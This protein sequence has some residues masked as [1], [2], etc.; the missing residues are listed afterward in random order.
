M[1]ILATADTPSFPFLW[2]TNLRGQFAIAF[3]DCTTYAPDTA[4]L[5][6]VDDVHELLGKMGCRIGGGEG[7]GFVLRSLTENSQIVRLAA[8]RGSV[9]HG[10]GCRKVRTEMGGRKGEKTHGCR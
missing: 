2:D 4:E 1:L 3:H 10:G 9:G 8:D 6:I 5:N 7:I